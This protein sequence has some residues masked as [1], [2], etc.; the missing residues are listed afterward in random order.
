MSQCDVSAINY[1]KSV[2]QSKCDDIVQYSNMSNQDRL[3][4]NYIIIFIKGLYLV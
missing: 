2:D 4:C 3:N 1:C